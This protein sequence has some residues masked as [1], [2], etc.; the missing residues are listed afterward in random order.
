MSDPKRRA[1]SDAGKGGTWVEA[2]PGGHQPVSSPGGAPARPEGGSLRQWLSRV[3]HP[4]RRDPRANAAD[5]RLAEME[6]ALRQAE[7]RCERERVEAIEL[8]TVLDAVQYRIAMLEEE[9]GARDRELASLRSSHVGDLVRLRGEQ[10]G[11]LRRLAEAEQEWSAERRRLE[12]ERAELRAQGAA[13]GDEIA[14]LQ[15]SLAS[16]VEPVRGALPRGDGGDSRGA[17]PRRR[18]E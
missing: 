8:R 13:L 12:A 2:P 1:P 17:L 11:A 9:V 16:R 14:A 15:T 7:E 18:G 3:E 6:A 10:E 5:P 4:P